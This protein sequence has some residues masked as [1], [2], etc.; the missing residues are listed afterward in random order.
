MPVTL[1]T[2]THGKH[3][4]L[5]PLDPWTPDR[6]DLG[7][8]HAPLPC[9]AVWEGAF[10]KWLSA[11]QKGDPPSVCLVTLWAP[12]SPT[13]SM[14]FLGVQILW[15]KGCLLKDHFGLGLPVPLAS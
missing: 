2:H 1:I 12:W 13:Y 8:G 9:K 11:C 6:A 10:R 7:L 4:A 3:T 15:R 14:S 5:G